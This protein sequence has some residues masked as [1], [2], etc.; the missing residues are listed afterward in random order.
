LASKREKLF[1]ACPIGK[2]NFLLSPSVHNFWLNV[3]AAAQSTKGEKWLWIVIQ[4]PQTESPS[5][6]SRAFFVTQLNNGS[7]VDLK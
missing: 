5:F 4:S 2:Q 6:L 3:L 1:T 7:L